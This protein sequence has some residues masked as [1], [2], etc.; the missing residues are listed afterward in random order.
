MEDKKKLKD[1]ELK[2]VNGGVDMLEELKNKIKEAKNEEELLKAIDENGQW[3]DE[4]L[5]N[6]F[7][8]DQ[9]PGAENTP[10]APR[11]I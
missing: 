10:S 11:P 8:P 5:W 4:D 6:V 2:K 7:G 3:T 1:E 9:W